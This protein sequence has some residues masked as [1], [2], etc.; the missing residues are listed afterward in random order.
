MRFI[1]SK[2]ETLSGMQKIECA[3][4]E[5]VRAR[6]IRITAANFTW[7]YGRSLAEFPNPVHM[8]VRVGSKCTSTDWL[9]VCLH[10]SGDRVARPDVLR[11]IERIVEMLAPTR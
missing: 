1:E 6:K 8:A 11:E 4:I 10:D 7:N 3:I 2:S 9:Q 5:Q